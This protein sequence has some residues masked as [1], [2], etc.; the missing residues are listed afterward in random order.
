MAQY[1]LLCLTSVNGSSV[2]YQNIFHI[3]NTEVL[4]DWKLSK[5]MYYFQV[6]R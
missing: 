1:P 5:M 4:Q 2:T 3:V 6:T